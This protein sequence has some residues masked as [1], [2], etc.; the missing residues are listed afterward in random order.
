PLAWIEGTL[1]AVFWPDEEPVFGILLGPP[2][3]TA[4]TSTRAK[5]SL[6]H[7]ECVMHEHETLR[8]VRMIIAAAPRERQEMIL[9]RAQELRNLVNANIDVGLAIALVGAE[10]AAEEP[11]F[12]EIANRR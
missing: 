5:K 1:A 9:R 2:I 6:W 4:Y 12:A 10:M 3:E 8:A 11:W 7:Q